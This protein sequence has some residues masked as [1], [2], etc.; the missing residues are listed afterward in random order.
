MDITQ[1]MK[2]FHT[3]YE[4][5]N[6]AGKVFDVSVSGEVVPEIHF[7]VRDLKCNMGCTDEYTKEMCHMWQLFQSSFS[8]DSMLRCC[9]VDDVSIN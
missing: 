7:V 1:L 4:L 3:I 2:A 5:F 8:K 9:V 6:D